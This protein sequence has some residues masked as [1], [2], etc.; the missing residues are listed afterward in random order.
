[1]EKHEIVHQL[2]EVCAPT[3]KACENRGGKTLHRLCGIHTVYYTCDYKAVKGLN[4]SGISHMLIDEASMISS[5]VWG[6]LAH[7]QRQYEFILIGFGDFNQLNQVKEERINFEILT[8]KT[9]IELY[10][11]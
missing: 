2:F 11:V 5:H 1:M 6:T 8:F 9:Y 4:H 7:I 3:H 10:A